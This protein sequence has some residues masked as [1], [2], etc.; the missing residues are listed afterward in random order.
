MLR[1]IAITGLAGLLLAGCASTPPGMSPNDMRSSAI[2]P[3]PDPSES[4]SEG[5]DL[6]DPGAG[7]IGGSSTRTGFDYPAIGTAFAG[8]RPETPYSMAAQGEAPYWR[9]TIEFHDL[10]GEV[11]GEFR[12][13][14]A[15]Q[16][17]ILT[18]VRLA[19]DHFV[20]G[21]R[22]YVSVTPEPVTVSA[23][24]QAGPCMDFDGI[25]RPFFASVRVDN[26][27][28][29]G[30]ARE[31][32][33]QWDWSRDILTRYDLILLCLSEVPGA[34]AAIDAY[35]PSEDNTAVRVLTDDQSRYECLIVNADERIASIRELDMTEVHLNE[36]RTVF[37][38]TEPVANECR[39]IEHIRSDDGTLM[40]VLAHDLCQNPRTHAEGPLAPGES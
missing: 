18:T 33:G 1:L 10:E 3:A 9:A 14:A 15:E 12:M 27:T 11:F 28:Y 7:V 5:L 20:N 21:F 13:I 16:E 39:A 38:T 4:S 23:A 32:G 29:G 17:P 25:E 34:V 22:R 35:S 2:A 36:G 19:P 31:E 8:T 6:A 26:E 40:G 37:L 30:C 24:F